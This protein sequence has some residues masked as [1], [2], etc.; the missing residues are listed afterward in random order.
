[1]KEE[2]GLMFEKNGV[3]LKNTLVKK[4]LE[5]KSIG[6]KIISFTD[7]GDIPDCLNLNLI[8]K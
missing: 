1:M 8:D 5:E 4:N 6:K 2:S 7:R 3:K